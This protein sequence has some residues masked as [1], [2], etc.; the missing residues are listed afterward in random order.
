MFFFLILNT[1]FTSE[2]HD[3]KELASK[4][5]NQAEISDYIWF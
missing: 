4:Y 3:Y 5:Y 1:Q 2:Y